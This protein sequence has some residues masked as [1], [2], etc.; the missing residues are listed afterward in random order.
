MFTSELQVWWPRRQRLFDSATRT[1]NPNTAR[2][3]T[4]ATML[5]ASR[6]LG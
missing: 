5:R 3:V 4:I 6:W 2:D 1:G